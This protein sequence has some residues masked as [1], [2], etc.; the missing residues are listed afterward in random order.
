MQTMAKDVIYFSQ[1]LIKLK[2]HIPNNLQRSIY[3][4]K[5]FLVSKV[6]FLC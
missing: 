2:Y 1:S 5:F 3:V 4:Y 6:F